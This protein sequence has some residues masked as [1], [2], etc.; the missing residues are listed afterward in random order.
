M[1]KYGNTGLGS[2]IQSSFENEEYELQMEELYQ[3]LLLNEL[4]ENDIKFSKDDIVFITKD[5]NARTVWLENGNDK[6]G[7]CHILQQH[8]EDFVKKGISK[9]E[10]S[11]LIYETV[12][13][14]TKTGEI[15]GRNRPVYKVEFKGQT[16]E[17]AITIAN[18]GF[19]VGAN[20]R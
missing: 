6:A 13:N 2:A 11:E 18:N 17:I 14:G 3:E 10:I 20:P 9:D 5:K 16:I 7:L 15:Q 1:G 8:G 19:I 12:V 4:E